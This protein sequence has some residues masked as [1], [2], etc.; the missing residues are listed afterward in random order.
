VNDFNEINSIIKLFNPLTNSPKHQMKITFA[1]ASIAAAVTLSST[2]E[3][4]CSP[5]YGQ[6][7]GKNSY[8]LCII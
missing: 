7:G 6:C 4:V 3:A 2:A 5:V 8:L 1:I